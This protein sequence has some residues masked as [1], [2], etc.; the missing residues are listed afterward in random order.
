MYMSGARPLWASS[1][2]KNIRP[3]RK[4]IRH[5]GV[6]AGRNRAY[7]FGRLLRGVYFYGV[8]QCSFGEVGAGVNSR[9]PVGAAL[10]KETRGAAVTG[11]SRHLSSL[12][13][14]RS[15]WVR[16]SCTEGT[17][18]LITRYIA[19]WRPLVHSSWMHPSQIS[20]GFSRKAYGHVL[21]CY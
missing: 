6:Y 3:A 15:A 9:N 10:M 20:I 19:G 21:L 2:A 12:F 11:D 13:T 4:Y 1:S 8:A 18:A 16:S 14:C 7:F 17:F 5:L